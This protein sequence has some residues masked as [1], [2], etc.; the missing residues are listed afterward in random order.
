MI[1]NVIS[2]SEDHTSFYLTSLRMH[3]SAHFCSRSVSCVCVGE[4]RV[5]SDEPDAW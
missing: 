3:W 5:F 1:A 4:T 2:P